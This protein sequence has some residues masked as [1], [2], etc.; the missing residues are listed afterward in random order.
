MAD[1][2][3]EPA[4]DG[5]DP[6][7]GRITSIAEQDKRIGDLEAG[8]QTILGKLDQLLGG[9]PPKAAAGGDA[10]QAPRPPANIAEEIR[11]QLD[12]RDAKHRADAET[13]A[14]DDRLAALETKT[15][16]LAEKSPEPLPR[17]VEKFMGWR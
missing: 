3:P 9:N 6:E 15:S 14:R 10:P 12:A 17:R 1:K 11:Q 7:A 8:Q 2:A 4:S 5:Q 16:E 13:K